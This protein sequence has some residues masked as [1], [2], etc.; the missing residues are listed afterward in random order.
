MIMK[1]AEGKGSL[2]KCTRDSREYNV[3]KNEDGIVAFSHREME[4]TTERFHSNIF[5]S[6]NVVPSPNILAGKTSPQ[7][8]PSEIRD[9]IGSMKLGIVPGPDR[10]SVDLLRAGDGRL[11]GILA[12]RFSSYLEKERIPDQCR[13]S[14]TILLHRK[15]DK[16]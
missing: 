2:K 5:R 8:L 14:C 15:S 10:I 12:A 6:L 4:S 11:L 3:L 16:R 13:T 7:I 1:A 9:A